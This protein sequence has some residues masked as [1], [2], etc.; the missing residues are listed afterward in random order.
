MKISQER[1]YSYDDVV[2]KDKR[3]ALNSRAD[4]SLD[5]E[6]F[7]YHSTQ[8][9]TGLPI[10]ISNMDGVGTFDLANIMTSHAGITC[11]H[12]HYSIKD[13]ESFYPKTLPYDNVWVS[14][15]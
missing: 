5:R 13:I 15:G 4:V 14:T 3:S 1:Y 11:L 6:F 9:W 10:I 8:K 7:F 2:I 12:K